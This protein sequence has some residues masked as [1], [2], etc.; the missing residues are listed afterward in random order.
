MTEIRRREF[1]ATGAALSGAVI[2]GSLSGG[3]AAAASPELVPDRKA[4]PKPPAGNKVRPGDL[5]IEPPTLTCLGFEWRIEGDDNRNA[6]VA[7]QYRKKGS[8]VWKNGMNLF[9]LNNER[10]F[11]NVRFDVISPNVFIGSIL[12]LEPEIGRA[13]V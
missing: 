4:K 1:L 9:R 13:H 10:V 12:D 6:S 5:F 2:A 8:R 3:S 11:S 7:V